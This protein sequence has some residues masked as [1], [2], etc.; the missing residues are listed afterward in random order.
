MQ[1]SQDSGGGCNLHVTFQL[2]YRGI[3]KIENAGGVQT[4][5]GNGIECRKGLWP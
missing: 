1:S 2:G 3:S 4:S 5:L